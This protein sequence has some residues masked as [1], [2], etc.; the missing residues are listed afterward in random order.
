MSTN[1]NE[2]GQKRKQSVLND[3][4][5][6][7]DDFDKDSA[8]E[9]SRDTS[10]LRNDQTQNQNQG[11]KSNSN[12]RRKSSIDGNGTN[13]NDNSLVFIPTD[14]YI[15]E[16]ESLRLPG[17]TVGEDLVASSSTLPSPSDSLNGTSSSST[18]TSTS[19]SGWDQGYKPCRVLDD[20]VMY[21]LNHQNGIIG[22]EE[23]G[24]WNE[25]TQRDVEVRVAGLVT[26]Q[27]VENDE[28]DDDD[29]DGE[30]DGEE[31]ERVTE[32]GKESEKGFRL[33]TTTIFSYAIHYDGD[34]ASSVWIETQYCWYLLR[35]P[36]EIYKKFYIRFYKAVCLASF[37]IQ[38]SLLNPRTTLSG[39]KSSLRK[40]FATF[41]ANK[42]QDENDTETTQEYRNGCLL[43]FS[44]AELTKYNNF[45]VHEIETFAE[46]NDR[47]ELIL[48]P[49]YQQLQGI[50]VKTSTKKQYQGV[51][52][53][54]STAGPNTTQRGPKKITDKEIEARGATVTPLIK[55]MCDK[56]DVFK[57]CTSV[58]EYQ[59]ESGFAMVTSPDGVPKLPELTVENVKS[60]VTMG[61]VISNLNQT[62]Y[63]NNVLVDQK[64]VSPGSYVCYKVINHLDPTVPDIRSILNPE[65]SKSNDISNFNRRIGLVTH[66]KLVKNVAIAHVHRL[67]ESSDTFVDRYANESE[68][69]L[70]SE[71]T[72]IPC[73]DIFAVMNPN[74][75]KYLPPGVQPSQSQQF[76]W[77]YQYTTEGEYLC[78]QNIYDRMKI[79]VPSLNDS[80]GTH[81]LDEIAIDIGERCIN[82]DIQ[83]SK[84]KSLIP[85]LIT[86]PPTL[87]FP[88]LVNPVTL[89]PS[90][91]PNYNVDKKHQVIGYSYQEK[92]YYLHDFV[93]I[94]LKPTRED[95]VWVIG[96]ITGMMENG[97]M[98][99]GFNNFSSPG[100][101]EL[102]DDNEELENELDS[103]SDESDFK[104]FF[105]PPSMSFEKNSKSTVTLHLRLFGRWDNLFKLYPSQF[106]P[107]DTTDERKLYLTNNY[108]T[109]S[110][111]RV[112]GS[113]WVLHRDAILDLNSFKEIRHTYWFDQVQMWDDFGSGVTEVEVSGDTDREKRGR[114]G[115]TT[116]SLFT[117]NLNSYGNQMMNLE[118]IKTVLYVHLQ[119]LKFE[120][121]QNSEAR[122]KG[123]TR[124]VEF[125]SNSNGNGNEL[126]GFGVLRALDLFAGCGGLTVGFDGLGK[127]VQDGE[128]EGKE[129][130]GGEGEEGGKRRKLSMRLESLVKTVAAVEFNKSASLTFEKNFPNVMVYNQDANMLLS[131][132]IKKFK[133][134]EELDPLV[135]LRGNKIMDLPRPGEI[136]FIYCGPPCQ[137]FSG[138]NQYKKTDDKKNA[139]IVLALSYVAFYQPKLFLLENVVGMVNGCLG[140]YQAGIHKTVGGV[141]HGA[142][143]LIIS[144]LLAMGYQVRFSVLQAGNQG[145]PQ[146]RRRFILIASKRHLPLPS[147]PD[148]TH[149]FKSNPV[150]VN[151]GVSGKKKFCYVKGA[152]LPGLTIS[153]G[154]N[155]LKPFEYVNPNIISPL[156]TEE[157]E[158]IY[159]PNAERYDMNECKPA[160]V[161][162]GRV[163][164]VVGKNRQEYACEPRNE[165]Q[166]K[167][168]MGS[169]QC[170]NHITRP[171][172]LEITERICR[173]SKEPG[174][175]HWSLPK[176][177]APWCLQ[178]ADSASAR[179]GGWKGLYG[180]FQPDHHFKTTITDVNP[181]NKQGTLLHWEQNRVISVRE[182][183][184]AQGFPDTFEFHAYNDNIPELYRHT[185]NAVPPVLAASLSWS[186]IVADK[187]RYFSKRNYNGDVMDLNDLVNELEALG[188][189]V[190]GEKNQGLND[191][192]E[193]EESNVSNES[194]K[195]KVQLKRM[196]IEVLVSPVKVKKLVE[197]S[198][199]IVEQL[200]V[201]KHIEV[202]Q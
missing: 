81:Q 25:I 184:R 186:V 84:K 171:Y 24:H 135:D 107:S 85:R 71:C 133:N 185:G 80:N 154:I 200:D 155:D 104:Q 198:V 14:T 110:P 178:H 55:Y 6:N 194:R 191:N 45:I 59:D 90:S 165:F 159:T 17:E 162:K 168:R 70:S 13:V 189:D 158:K 101:T 130:I 134:N 11:P 115:L 187:E 180:R 50:T 108:V 92:N 143:K 122:G 188:V 34:G 113:C 36:A 83:S 19:P 31:G 150:T 183:A 126:D 20:F 28:D 146:S 75:I 69:L 163:N 54:R 106:T 8:I 164:Y 44:P 99:A 138:L 64:I 119:R 77:R 15:Q 181:M 197:E 9:G 151:L 173:V 132:A 156:S 196:E 136:D 124:V 167:L 79:V 62:R 103:S 114:I 192:E 2:N 87:H 140:G 10:V 175:D 3:P 182:T 72:D 1:T 74:E 67:Y 43:A 61:T 35:N 179:H 127:C 129:N 199:S 195:G 26:P 100:D 46:E 89:V 141:K 120:R 21:D 157:L 48:S 111:T 170:V 29:G 78:A 53:D 148:V 73:T 169:T 37:I 160:H 66:L 88:E 76:W 177:L 93:Y 58:V 172:T 139:M 96:Q 118:Y 97:K 116:I 18:S 40:Y 60:S 152:P 121:Q 86:T 161:P 147:F 202:G 193:E 39:V 109:V 23:I 16:T 112:T 47:M 128:G 4:L 142:P 12:K 33:T 82:C 153:D 145:V 51:A 56:F 41:T 123:K 166:R 38:K 63:L 68:L 95:Q 27:F 52:L 174:S 131:R 125:N 5:Q 65:N 91:L 98:V 201:E 137:G 102:P 30:G 57:N 190:T 117:V 22:I 32:G 49:V 94:A 176:E 42:I 149:L 144:A 105:K 7:P